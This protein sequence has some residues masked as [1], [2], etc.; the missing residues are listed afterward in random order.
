MLDNAIFGCIFFTQLL[1]LCSLY[2]MHKNVQ[3]W[4]HKYHE[5]GKG[6]VHTLKHRYEELYDKTEEMNKYLQTS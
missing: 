1:T 5:L 4:A 6:A 2:M 3:K